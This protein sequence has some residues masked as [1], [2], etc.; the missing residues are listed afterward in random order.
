MPKHRSRLRSGSWVLSSA[1]SLVADWLGA[2][3]M[4]C[5]PASV[6]QS[7]TVRRSCQPMAGAT[8]SPVARSHTHGGGPLVGDA[9]GIDRAAAGER[10]PGHVEHGRGH[11]GGVEL[12]QAGERRVGRQG[13]VVDVGHRGVR[14]HDGGPQPARADVDDED[15]HRRDRSSVGEQRRCRAGRRRCPPSATRSEARDDPAPRRSSRPGRRRI[16]TP[17]VCTTTNTPT[18]VTTPWVR[19]RPRSWRH[20]A[21]PAP[22]TSPASTITTQDPQ[23]VGLVGR[24]LSTRPTTPAGTAIT[25]ATR[26]PSYRA[27]ASSWPVTAR[28][29][30]TASCSEVRREARACPG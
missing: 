22:S 30:A 13:P 28:F 21:T 20:A 19:G 1:A 17:T 7:N 2:R 26:A 23:P 12:D 29:T 27:R 10:R 5:S 11:L 6:R 3:R 4:P 8:G 18:A 15:A 9:D 14:S 16:R 25:A 24:S